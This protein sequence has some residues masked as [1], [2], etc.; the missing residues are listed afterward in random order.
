[1]ADLSIASQFIEWSNGIILSLGYFG[2]FIVS[3]IGSASVIFP[4]PA[5]FIIPAGIFMGL[6]PWLVG[7]CAGLGSAL[8]EITGYGFGKGGGKVIE[9]K[10]KKHI[11]KY[12][13]WF[14]K[15]RV[16]LFILLF[17]ATPLPD[18]I[19][20]LVCGVFNYDLKK[21]ILA[22]IIGKVIL[23]LFIAF[24]SFYGIEIILNMMG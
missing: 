5:F 12:R 14:E 10:Y 21:F 11:E 7:I 16:F 19:L 1:M 13:K 15:D 3:F 4:V 17:A 8:G 18:D 22:S 6:N 23:N 20:G 24:A 2:I 9:K